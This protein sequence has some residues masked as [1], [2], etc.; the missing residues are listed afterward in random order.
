MKENSP[1][2]TN[3][4][5]RELKNFLKGDNLRGV[6]TE[7][8]ILFR[9]PAFPSLS[10][11]CQRAIKLVLEAVTTPKERGILAATMVCRYNSSNKEV[12]EAK[13]SL[14]LFIS[15]LQ[16]LPGW[17]LP[18]PQRSSEEERPCQV[19]HTSPVDL[20]RCEKFITHKN[21]QVSRKT[22]EKL[23]TSSLTHGRPL[24]LR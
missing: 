2:P 9:D 20:A 24:T 14:G 13:K 11:E 1:I 19:L 6:G 4:A 16:K 22:K 7:L 5:T 10:P 8:Y 3:E 12:A 15:R 17:C 21:R 23:S 18:F